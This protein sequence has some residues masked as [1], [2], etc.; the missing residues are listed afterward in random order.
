MDV[1]VRQHEQETPTL[2]GEV[3]EFF[4]VHHDEVME[5]P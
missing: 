5:L 3:P 1:H 2:Q 4:S